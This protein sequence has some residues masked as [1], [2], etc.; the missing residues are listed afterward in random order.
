MYTGTVLM[1]DL[2]N[3]LHRLPLRIGRLEM[4]GWACG[5]KFGAPVK[6]GER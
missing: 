1:M 2:V 6:T 5:V 4:I 3:S